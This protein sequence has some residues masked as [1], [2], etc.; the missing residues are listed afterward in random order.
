MFVAKCLPLSP[1]RPRIDYDFRIE[2]DLLLLT[3]GPGRLPRAVVSSAPGREHIALPAGI[4]LDS[5]TVQQ[6]LW[7]VLVAALRRQAEAILPGHLS[8]LA[9]T[10]R[11]HRVTIKDIHTRWGSC[12]SLGNINLSL[13]LMLAPSH[14]VDYVLCHELAHLREM[15]H[16]P[17]FWALLDEMTGGR[18]RLLER[19]MRHFGHEK[20]P[21]LSYKVPKGGV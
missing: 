1:V 5:E 16:G 21:F 19:E 9:G 12:S 18:A 20:S 4:D 8:R 15:N 10:L 13:W 6:W 11:Y 14:L 17:R 2:T 7:R 3:F